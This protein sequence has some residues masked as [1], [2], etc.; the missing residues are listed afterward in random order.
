MRLYFIT[1]RTLTDD[2]GFTYEADTSSNSQITTM[3]MH[4]YS[5]VTRYNNTCDDLFDTNS[6]LNH[7]LTHTNMKT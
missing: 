3:A 6:Y 4:D 2:N 5:I 7:L 1:H